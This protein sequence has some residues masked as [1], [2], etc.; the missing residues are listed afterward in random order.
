ARVTELIDHAKKEA[1]NLLKEAELKA[2]DDLYKKREEADREIE[3][4]RGEVQEEQRRIEQARGEVREEERRLGERGGV[5]LNKERTLHH[6]QRKLVE[7]RHEVEK[8]Q[9]D[10]EAAISKETQLL[11]QIS[12]LGREQAE[13]MLLERLEKEMADDVAIRIQ[14][15]EDMLKSTCE[16]KA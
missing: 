2:K 4:K 10:L 6:S 13:A 11:H 8:R 9:E 1:D 7:K 3:Q 5:P 14:K 12:A 15:H 16:E